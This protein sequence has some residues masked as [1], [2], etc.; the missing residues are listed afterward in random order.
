MNNIVST[1]RIDEKR[2]LRNVEVTQGRIMSEA[3]M[4]AL[5]KKGMNRQEAHE[6]LRKLT[7]KSELEKTSFRQVLLGNKAVTG[8]LT[9]RDIDQALD[10]CS[11]LGTAAKQVDLMVEKT[12]AERKASGLK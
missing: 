6:L 11:Y 9:K 4:V 8:R 10:A 2:M 1:L 5:T 3:V 12:E 7:I